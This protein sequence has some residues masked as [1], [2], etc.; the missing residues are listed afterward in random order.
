MFIGC[1]ILRAFL[2]GTSAEKFPIYLGWLHRFDQQL[3]LAPERS[4]IS[5]EL[6]DRLTGT[7]EVTFLKLR[8][9]KGTNVYRLLQDSAP[10]FLRI[11][12]AEMARQP[13]AQP[14]SSISVARILASTRYELAHFILLDSLFSMLYAL[15][16]VVDY[17]T[18]VMPLESDVHPVEWFHGCPATFQATLVDINSLFHRKQAESRLDWQSIEWYLKS[19]QPVVQASGDGESWGTIARLAIQESWRHSLLIYLYM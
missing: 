5:A 13:A 12:L 11:A 4:A 15:P 14:L 18:S 8:L 17:D 10:V 1:N 6:R 2:D 3:R 19:W 16:Q 7:L 9:F